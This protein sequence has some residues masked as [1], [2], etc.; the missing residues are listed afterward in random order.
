MTRDE[1]L[2]EID[3]RVVEAEVRSTTL[4][5]EVAALSRADGDSTEMVERLWRAMDGLAELRRQR[6]AF[7]VIGRLD[8]EPPGE[9]RR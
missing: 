4:A 9:D 1:I 3:H 6:S 8:P 7:E 2:R 5:A